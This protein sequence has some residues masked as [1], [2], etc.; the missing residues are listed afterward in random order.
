MGHREAFE[1][2]I[3]DTFLRG[4]TAGSK[5]ISRSKG[6]RVVRFLS[7]KSC[8]EDAHFKYWVKSRGLRLMDYPSLG[9]K[10]ILCVPAKAVV[11]LKHVY[12]VQR[13]NLSLVLPCLG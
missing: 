1:K 2:Y 12:V 4:K 9:L 10:N 13:F 6:E 8:D 3:N 11:N 5:T 7:G